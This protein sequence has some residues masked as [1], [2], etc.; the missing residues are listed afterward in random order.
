MLRRIRDERR[1]RHDEVGASEVGDVDRATSI[2]G[3]R[4]EGRIAH[5]RGAL[6][7]VNSATVLPG[8]HL[9]PGSMNLPQAKSDLLGGW[10]DAGRTPIGW[11]AS[12]THASIS[13]RPLHTPHFP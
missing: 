13:R 11:L 8:A 9:A 12:K 3:I 5:F 6:L 7:K 10:D 2:G 1:A 4:D